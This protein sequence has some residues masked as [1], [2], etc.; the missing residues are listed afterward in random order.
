MLIKQK[1]LIVALVS[2]LV[3]SLVLVLTLIGYLAYIE[4]KGEEFKRS[5]NE[6][7]RKAN[8]KVYSKRLDISRLTARMEAAGALKGKPIIEGVIKNNGTKDITD[9]SISVKF[10]DRDGATI[11]EETF[12][13]QEPS[14]GGGELAIISIPYLSA[15]PRVILRPGK[16]LPFKKILSNC[17]QEIVMVLREDKGVARD[18]GRWSGRL[19]FEILSISF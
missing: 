14:L 16:H 3:V 6:L 9:L 17:P 1:S 12:H 19:T 8:A 11:Y 18:A 2:G 10:L 4:L 13:P 7:L 15:T 5:Y